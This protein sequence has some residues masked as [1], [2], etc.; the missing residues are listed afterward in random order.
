M[1][2]E[3]LMPLVAISA[4]EWVMNGLSII[5]V[6]GVGIAYLI[7]RRRTSEG[8]EG[9]PQA[10]NSHARVTAGPTYRLPGA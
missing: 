2:A 9:A 5:L 7:G 6:A 8:M 4:L 1:T 10:S 3:A